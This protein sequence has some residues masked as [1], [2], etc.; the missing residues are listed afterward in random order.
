MSSETYVTKYPDC[1]ICKYEQD[2]IT[3]AHYD[4][5]TLTG[6]WGYMCDV[7]FA[8]RGTG[9]GTGKGQRLIVGD[10]PVDTEERKRRKIREAINQG[11]FDA[12]EE[13]IGDGDPADF[14]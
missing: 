13:L 1:D 5:Q 11:D 8:S 12:A 9:L 2:R 3:E 7:H 14:F 4:G 10:K 6:Q